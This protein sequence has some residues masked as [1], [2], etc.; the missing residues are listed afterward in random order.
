MSTT[1]HFQW[2]LLALEIVAD[3]ELRSRHNTM[4][5]RVSSV[6]E[7]ADPVGTWEHMWLEKEKQECSFQSAALF[8]EASQC[9][10][11]VGLLIIG[12]DSVITVP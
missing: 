1:N 4:F 11:I 9:R 7:N 6:R 2:H 12:R 10:A 3:A 5:L 8:T